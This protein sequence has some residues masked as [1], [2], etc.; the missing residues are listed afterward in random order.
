MGYERAMEGDWTMNGLGTG[1]RGFRRICVRENTCF[2]R[3]TFQ[4]NLRAGKHL[5]QL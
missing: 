2:R 4:A 5:E 3:K 1:K